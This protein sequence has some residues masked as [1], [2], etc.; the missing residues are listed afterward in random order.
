MLSRAADL[1]KVDFREVY[2]FLEKLLFR[3]QNNV[4][5]TD[6]LWQQIIERKLILYN[7][8]LHSGLFVNVL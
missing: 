3:P 8:A 2:G 7:A 5:K 1:A 6:G 4:I